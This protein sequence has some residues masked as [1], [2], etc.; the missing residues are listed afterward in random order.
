MRVVVTGSRGRL[1]R[2]VVA[3]LARR[4]E[5]LGVDSAAGDGAIALDLLDQ[6]ATIGLFR[7]LRPDAVIHLAAISV[8]FSA[9]ETQILEVN[10]RLSAN[11]LV[12]AQAA[13]VG[14]VIAASSPT[15]YG[16]GREGWRPSALPLDER[17][18]VQP[19]HAYALSKVCVEELFAATA[20]A[21]QGMRTA[22]FRPAYV[23]APEEWLGAPTQQ[24]HTVLERLRRPELAAVS[25]FNY[26][27]ARDVAGFLEAWLL[28]DGPALSA[29]SR[30]VVAAPDVLATAPTAELVA[31]HLPA[32]AGM[33]AAIEGSA[34]LFDSSAAARELGWTATR[35]WR[36]ELPREAQESLELP[37]GSAAR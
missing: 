31:D 10:L 27:D 33:A 4:H 25:L 22:T 15:V 11:V 2:S 7:A 30:Y 19:W 35:T 32:L 14:R 3:E 36:S 13:D 8:P 34:S 18:P 24:G 6:E 26:V 9:P 1:G 17:E 5:V 28:S 21:R 23:I 12:A 16:Y 29:G 37:A 20:R